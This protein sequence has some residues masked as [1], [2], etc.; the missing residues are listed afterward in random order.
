[1]AS[2]P[3]DPQLFSELKEAVDRGL[4]SGE[5]MTAEQISSHLSAFRSRFG[6][7][8]LRRTDGEALLSL[9]H[10]RADASSK[11]LTYWLEFKN[12][13][14]FAGNRFGGIGGGSAL[15]YG[16]YQRQ[17]DGEWVTGTPTV[18]QVISVADAIEIAR[19]Q[20]DELVNGAKVLAAMDHHDCS[21]DAYARLQRGMERAAPSLASTAWAHKYWFLL[22]SRQLDDYHSPKYQRFHLIKLLQM[23]PDEEGIMNASGP[24]FVCAGRFVSLARSLGVHVSTLNR[25]LNLRDGAFHSYWRIDVTEEKKG[26]SL[27]PMMREGGYISIGWPFSVPDLTPFLIENRAIL[28]SR[29]RHYLSPAGTE[30]HTVSRK[31]GDICNFAQ[32]MSEKDIVVACEGQRVLG[33]GKVAG[34]YFYESELFTPHKRAVEWLSLR[35][36]NLPIAEGLRAAVHPLGRYADNLLELERH[37]AG[38]QPARATVTIGQPM[39]K[40]VPLAAVDPLT[41]RI[42]NILQRKGQVILYGP[43]GTGKTYHALRTARELTARRAFGKTFEALS[44]DQRAEIGPVGLVNLCTFH[45]GYSYEDFVEGLRPRVTSSGQMVFDPRPGIFKQLCEDA[46]KQPRKDFFLIIDEINRGDLPRIFG[47]LMTLVEHDKRE[48]PVTLPVTQA[49]FSI[50]RNVFLIGT[51]NTA[52]RSISLLDAAFRRRFGFVELMPDSSQLGDRR[53]GTLPLGPWLDALNMRLRRSLKRDSRNLQIGHA[54][55][56]TQPITSVAEFARVLRDEIVPLIE[57]YCYDDLGTLQEIL[58]PE[59]VDVTAARI[60]EEIFGAN[61]E[62]ELIQA[63]SY[64][65]MEPLALGTSTAADTAEQPIDEEAGDAS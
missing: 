26:E 19:R 29:V 56:S 35:E 64:P 13:E 6:V 24:R 63:V 53:A 21:D 44:D 45:P 51:M 18:Q 34:S 52:D 10:G 11:C 47:E 30:A 22:S 15:K 60:R 48:L 33:I 9:L 54:Y 31:A 20:R 59:L 46:R 49:S 27:W 50:P 62:D 37:L 57:E 38:R 32:E 3:L 5:L 41:A 8:V 1:M 4:A 65:E 43:P 55:L 7:S 39:S 40:P 61:R 36:W 2:F 17:A 14:E 58:G 42:E 28:R 23:P 16:I 25:A 12:D